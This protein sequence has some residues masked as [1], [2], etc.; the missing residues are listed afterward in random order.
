MCFDY[1]LLLL[2]IRTYLRTLHVLD[3][4]LI[5]IMTEIITRTRIIYPD[6]RADILFII[7]L[8]VDEAYRLPNH[9][10]LEPNAF[11]FICVKCKC[12]SKQ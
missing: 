3:L 5:W 2:Y 7:S 11:E 1:L 12:E 6:F 10:L 9:I 8:I 4:I